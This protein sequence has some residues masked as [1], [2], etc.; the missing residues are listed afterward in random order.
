[1]PEIVEQ[2]RQSIKQFNF[3]IRDAAGSVVESGLHITVSAGIAAADPKWQGAWVENIT[4]CA[5]R[6]LY[7]AKS[8]GRD[9]AVEYLHDGEPTFRIVKLSAPVRKFSANTTEDDAGMPSGGCLPP[10]ARK[11]K[12]RYSA[13]SS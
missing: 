10:R 9:L 13:Q 7:Y 1:L 2:I 12:R 5:D 6:A 3:L 4:D 11:P 8:N